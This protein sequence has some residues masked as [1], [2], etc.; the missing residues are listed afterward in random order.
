MPPGSTIC[1]GRKLGVTGQTSET[2]GQYIAWPFFIQTTTLYRR[3]HALGNWQRLPCHQYK[4]RLSPLRQ[5]PGCHTDRS[6][7]ELPP[8]RHESDIRQPCIAVS[9][10]QSARGFIRLHR[11]AGCRHVWHIFRAVTAETATLEK[12]GHSISHRPRTSTTDT[13]STCRR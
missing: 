7:I 6:R 1:P 5:Q 11:T 13:T 8:R 10:R 9:W 4:G 3:I 2:A 12:P